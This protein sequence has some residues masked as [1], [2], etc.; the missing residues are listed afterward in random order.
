MAI[1]NF[2]VGTRLGIGFGIML[3]LMIAT[4]VIT[5]FSLQSVERSTRLVIEESL[6]YTLQANRMVQNVIQT[7]QFYTD[8][9]ATRSRD[10]YA[11]AEAHIEEF[12][13]GEAKFKAMFE[14][15]QDQQSLQQLEA[16]SKAFEEFAAT[17][18]SMA[19]AYINSGQEAGDRLMT[20]FDADSTQVA[21]LVRDFQAT[22]ITEINQ[23]GNAILEVSQEAKNLQKMLGMIALVFGILITIFTTRSIVRPL[24]IAVSAAL[25]LAVGKIDLQINETRND[26]L[27]DLLQAMRQMITSNREV[28]AV[29]QEIA[30]GNL[31]VK[32]NPRSQDDTLLLALA[33]MVAK[34]TDVIH[35]VKFASANVTSGSQAMS[36]TAEE[37]SQG[38]TEQA[39]AAEEASSSVEQMTA[40]IRQNADNAI[41]TE[42]IAVKAAQDALEGGEAVTHTLAAMKDIAQKIMIVEEIARQTNLLALNAAIEAARAGE[43]GKGFAVVASEVRKLAERSQTSAQE[44]SKLSISSV[45][46]AEK[47]GELLGI[48]V[49]NIRKTAELVQEISAASKEQDAGA[50]QINRAIQQLDLVIQQN[51]SASEEMASTSE[52]LSSQSE[53][54]EEMIAFFSLDVQQKRKVVKAEALSPAPV[55]AP[56]KKPAGQDGKPAPVKAKQDVVDIKPAPT[57]AR[58]FKLDGAVI[59]LSAGGDKHDEE[60]ERF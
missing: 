42:K 6:P 1:I 44:I 48:L 56:G 55:R 7:Q 22:Q 53:Q 31:A 60:F 27:G 45:E 20:E 46:I 16:L 11:E 40:N 2:K 36:A 39:A 51:A 4:L 58:G 12:H 10:S 38:A 32:V 41:Q 9:S 26:E 33:D 59:D 25:E 18:K 15:E 57:R 52:E 47:A 37:M 13:A 50:E 28:S 19:E 35:N 21:T 29:A 34:L 5:F 8:A 3:I 23:S 54:L 49:P 43:H 30:S 24:S 14:K 17:G